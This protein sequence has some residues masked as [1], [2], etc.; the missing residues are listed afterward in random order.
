MKEYLKVKREFPILGEALQGGH[1][2]KCGT[3]LTTNIGVFVASPYAGTVILADGGTLNNLHA[4]RD[5]G[6]DE[7]AAYV[8]FVN[9][10]AGKM[11]K[12]YNYVDEV[13]NGSS[14]IIAQA[15]LNFSSD[16]TTRI[17][18]PSDFTNLK[19]APD[20]LPNQIK[21]EW[22]SDESAYGSVTF[23]STDLTFTLEQSGLYQLKLT[24]GTT[25]IFID[26]TTKATVIISNLIRGTT[27]K[28]RAIKFNTNGTNLLAVMQAKLVTQPLV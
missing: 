4:L 12:I 23:T 14:I 20:T 9:A 6:A 5:T 17:G 1:M 7:I 26:F 3:F 8:A 28:T 10:S 27:V 25:V 19:Y 18:V 11:E 16:N 15:G 24:V 22:K 13:A 2:I 21:V